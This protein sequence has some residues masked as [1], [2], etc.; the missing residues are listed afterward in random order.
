MECEF[1]DFLAFIYF[2]LIEGKLNFISKLKILWNI[3]SKNRIGFFL[4]TVSFHV[5]FRR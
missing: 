2:P 3:F 5:V 1:R 4:M